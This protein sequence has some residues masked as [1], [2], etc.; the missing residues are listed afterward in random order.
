MSLL[1][2]MNTFWNVFNPN[3]F[4]SWE[5]KLKI[6][7]KKTNKIKKTFWIGSKVGVGQVR[8]NKLFFF[9]FCL[10]GQLVLLSSKLLFFENKLSIWKMLIL[11]KE[12]FV[13]NNCP[14]LT[15]MLVSIFKRRTCVF[16]G[17][18]LRG[19]NEW[20]AKYWAIPLWNLP[21]L[22]W[23]FFWKPTF[24]IIMEKLD[25]RASCKCAIHTEVLKT[26]VLCQ[27]FVSCFR[28]CVFVSFIFVIT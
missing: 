4:I 6:V 17:K 1:F 16:K 23:K 8:P 9:F 7:K 21:P 15:L 3:I 27:I 26:P 24:V 11:C 19:L 18:I 2:F 10:I 28:I 12:N 25:W 22:N 14:R 13:Q 5:K 20:F